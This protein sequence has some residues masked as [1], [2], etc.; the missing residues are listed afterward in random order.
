[1]GV[2]KDQ[3]IMVVSLETYITIAKGGLDLLSSKEVRVSTKYKTVDKKVKSATGPLPTN[4]EEQRK[5]VSADPALRRLVDI[6]HNFTDETWS[7]L[8]IDAEKFLRLLE[9]EEQFQMM[10]RSSFDY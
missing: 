7:K 6:G 3:T 4:S 2:Q 8:L 5:E 9:E 10:L 1:M